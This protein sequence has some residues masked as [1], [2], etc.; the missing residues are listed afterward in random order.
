MAMSN[1]ERVG[2][3]FELLAA[4][5]EPFV[6]QVMTAATGSVGDW[7]ALLE[8]R[9]NQ[10]QGVAKKFSRSDPAL[11]LKVLTDERRAFRDRLS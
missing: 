1:R 2:R 11:L 5:L 8:A 7:L 3:G 6:D 9:E 10:R 4:G